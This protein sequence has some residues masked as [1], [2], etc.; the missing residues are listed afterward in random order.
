MTSWMFSLGS[1]TSGGTL[2]PLFTIGGGLGALLGA[3]AA[4]LL[5]AAGIDARVAAL[6]GMAAIFA[7]ASRALLASVVFAFETT[8]QPMGLL[9]L[10]GGCAAAYLISCLA[11]R[12]SIM[13]EKIA[14][15]G[16]HA[17]G[18]YVADFLATVV[19]RDCMSPAVIT[20]AADQSLAE[21]RDFLASSAP[22]HTHQGFPVVDADGKVVGV[23]T[24]RDLIDLA[25]ASS[26]PLRALVRRK[27]VVITDDGNLREAV[28]RMAR[29]GVGRLPVVDRASGR[30]CGILSRSDVLKAEVRRL[31]EQH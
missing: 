30:L 4:A 23:L 6:V 15:R 11:M 19:V 1:G 5:P 22:G 13:T 9:P 14:R 31:D 20:L 27:P 7:G 2:A 18:E 3:A 28:G 29:A 17:A 24:R 25:R 8:R 12:N 26:E 16:V 10:L 21:A